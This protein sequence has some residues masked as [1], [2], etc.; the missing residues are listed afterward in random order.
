MTDLEAGDYGGGFELT[1]ILY[2]GGV[3]VTTTGKIYAAG[4]NYEP[5]F[6]FGTQ[7]SKGD[8]VG[9]HVDTGNTYDATHGIPVVCTA[10]DAAPIIGVVV[11]EPRWVHAPQTTT[12]TWAADLARGAYRTAV[13]R[14]F[15]VTAAHKA[16]H[17]TDAGDILVGNPVLYDVSADGWEDA[18]TT[19]TGAFSFHWATASGA[20]LLVGF[21]VYAADASDTD[22]AGCDT[23]A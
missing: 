2:E 16:L 22:C 14:Y 15:C 4:T 12:A 18:G 10:A 19:Y 20:Y 3:T 17:S 5:S 6:A 8:Y 21:G 13:V 11:T 23:V 9:L 1:T 7:I